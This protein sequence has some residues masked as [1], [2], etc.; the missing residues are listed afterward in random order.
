M[1]I[2]EKGFF[3][4]ILSRDAKWLWWTEWFRTLCLLSYVC[5]KPQIIGYTTFKHATDDH[6]TL[7]HG[8]LNTI[9][10]IKH[11]KSAFLMGNG[12]QPCPR[13]NLTH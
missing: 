9:Y 12:I 13:A 8:Q 3:S 4:D 1:L 11:L 7:K 6:T 2:V 10:I 5:K